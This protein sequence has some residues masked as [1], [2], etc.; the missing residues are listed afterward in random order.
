MS[1]KKV[2]KIITTIIGY[3]IAFGGGF[4]LVQSGLPNILLIITLIVVYGLFRLIAKL[5]S[6]EDEADEVIEI[7]PATGIDRVLDKMSDSVVFG[8][9]SEGIPAMVIGAIIGGSLAV[10]VGLDVNTGAF[11][12]GLVGF[13]AIVVLIW[14]FKTHPDKISPKTRL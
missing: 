11:I 10:T 7:K 14:W 6:I 2:F 4:F 8:L 5:L 12:G 1:R 9:I 3:A 13:G